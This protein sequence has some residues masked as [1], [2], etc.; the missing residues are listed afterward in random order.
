MASNSGRASSMSPVSVVAT[1]K[2]SAPHHQFLEATAKIA[3]VIF[4]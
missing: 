2:I 3:R 1:A 4:Q